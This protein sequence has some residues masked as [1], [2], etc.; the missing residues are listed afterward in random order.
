MAGGK[1]AANFAGNEFME[2]GA[3]GAEILSSPS[4]FA[5][6]IAGNRDVAQ[7]FMDQ[8]NRRRSQ[9]PT[10]E[11]DAETAEIQ[12]GWMEPI[13]EAMSNMAQKYP[14]EAELL[15]DVVSDPSIQALGSLVQAGE[16]FA[17]VSA[18]RAVKSFLDKPN[19]VNSFKGGTP[20][21]QKGQ[22]DFGLEPEVPFKLGDKLQAREF[23]GKKT[24]KG[25]NEFAEKQIEAR[26][27][28][29]DK[30]KGQVS[31]FDPDD[32][33]GTVYLIDD[34]T[35][36]F[37]IDAD[38]YIGHVFKHPDA[39]RS[40]TISAAMTKAR[41]EGGKNLDAFN[42]GKG[43]GDTGL[44]RGYKNTGAVETDRS[45]FNPDWSTP[46]VIDALGAKAPD[47]VS[48][49]VG[50]VFPE[51]KHSKTLGPREQTALP[52]YTQT[53][54]GKPVAR[55]PSLRKIL[56]PRAE[57]FNRELMRKGKEMGFDKWYHTGGIKDTFM[58]YNPSG[59]EQVFE[60]LMSF[61]AGLSPRTKV[62][63]EI[64]RASALNYMNKRGADVSNMTHD[65]F[66]PGYG[67]PLTQSTQA[68]LIKKYMET[69][70]VGDP[71]NP[72]KAPSYAQN[73]MGNF[74]P[75]TIDTRD[76]EL[77]T[78]N[79]RTGK[80]LKRGPTKQEYPYIEEAQSS[81]AADLGLEPAEGQSSK[82]GAGEELVKGS[83]SRN[84]TSAFNQRVAK[85]AEHH[86]ISEDEVAKKLANRDIILK[87]FLG[88]V[89]AGTILGGMNEQ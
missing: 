9:L 1:T 44:V 83:D 24:K 36:G 84:L 15:S 88:S 16:M 5:Q 73:K 34:G 48:M 7:Q 69:G 61:G 49:D 47:Y 32:F 82:W 21:G 46:E 86:G 77:L 63:Q 18:T 43:T 89:G 68:P 17:P 19:T 45:D 87:A 38:G 67:H 13:S 52:R 50:G 12:S 30:D 64:R 57:K 54:T 3:S 14:N 60:D 65:M 11:A 8:R 4:M 85:T 25:V 81:W 28:M 27:S 51:Y 74:K 26:N 56:S 23:T 71:K 75:Y 80:S 72:M 10:F 79:P 66:P 70:I 33:D 20:A 42:L 78:Y 31:P 6:S 58:D 37:T 40:G 62:A 53:P 55:P 2:I 39:S 41:A 59:G 22:I 29:P 35:A 76:F